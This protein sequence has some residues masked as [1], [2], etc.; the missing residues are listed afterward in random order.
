MAHCFV[1]YEDRLLR[2]NREDG[3]WRCR[4]TL[5]GVQLDDVAVHPAAPDVVFCGT[6]GQGLQ[7]S[8]DGGDSWER[9][10]ADT[11]D[12]DAVTAVTIDPDDPDIVYAGTEP[13]RVYRSTDI[14]STW[15]RLSGLL[16]VPS[17][18]EWSFPPRPETH[19]VRFL[20]VA[21]TDSDHLYVSI[22][23]GAVV[24]STDAGDT[25]EDRVPTAL[26]D[27]HWI[28]THEDAPQ[29]VCLA[30]GDG[31]VESND[32]G[33]TFEHL[34]DGLPVTYC[35]SVALDPND[36]G[37]AFLTAASGPRTAHRAAVAESSMFRKR[38]EGDWVRLDDAPAGEGVLRPVLAPGHRA[39]ELYAATNTG[40]FRT[41]TAG[42]DW[43][44]LDLEWPPV[45]ES[46]TARGI[47]VVG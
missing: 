20:E 13:S 31:Y 15:R 28:A 46:Q 6:V 37:M 36:P 25:W 42:D 3:E 10:G 24:Q 23:A 16:D 39:G 29:R 35:W 1:A 26:R 40:L 30:G 41:T 22:E 8:Q 5:P 27:A 43:E 47:A 4:T 18:S 34:E 44:R 12:P 17:A 11:I 32:G 21:A 33:E 7:R 2:A 19:H 9:V 45:L 14:G 38:G